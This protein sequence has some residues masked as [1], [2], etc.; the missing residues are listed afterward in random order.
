MQGSSL[1]F[2]SEFFLDQTQLGFS[3]A[4]KYYVANLNLYLLCHILLSMNLMV[5]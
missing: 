2:V 4:R 1:L 3:Q 5:V